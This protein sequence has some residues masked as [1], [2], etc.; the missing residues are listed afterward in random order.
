MLKVYLVTLLIGQIVHF[1]RYTKW[2]NIA[3]G[4]AKYYVNNVFGQQSPTKTTKLKAII[5]SFA[6]AG[7]WTRDLS[8]HSLKLY[9]FATETTDRID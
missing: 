7:N 8:N 6:R 2:I 9:L 5:K 4:I 1:V 3:E